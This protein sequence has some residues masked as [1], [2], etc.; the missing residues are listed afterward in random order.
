MRSKVFSWFFALG[1]LLLTSQCAQIVIPGGGPKDIK[2]PMVEKYIP[3]SAA[4]NFTAKSIVI[5]FDEFIQLNDLQKELTISP[6][7]NIQP[8]V[9]VK[10]K[11]LLIDIKDTL[12]KN[13]TYVLN[14]GNSIKDFTEG[15][16]KADF[17]YIFSTGGYIDT[18]KLSGT[19]KNAYDQKTDKGILV[20]LY[21]SSDDSVPYKKGPSYFARTNADGTYRITNIRPGTYKAFALKETNANFKYDSPDES[22]AFSD[23]LIKIRKNTKL[24]L[25]LF[26]EEPKKQRMLK[27][28]VSGYGN[29]T[30]MYA[31]PVEKISFR[32]LNASTPTETFITEYSTGRDTIQ[33]WSP[34]FGKDSLYFKVIADEK[35]VDTMKTCTCLFEKQKAGRADVFKLVMNT[36]VSPT[37]KFDI[38]KNVTLRFNHPINTALSR[39]ENVALTMNS[40]RIDYTNRDSIKIGDR[41]FSFKFP[42]IPDSTYQLNIP[43]ATFTDIFNLKNDTMKIKF[44]VQE[45]KFYGTLKL[46][47][48]MKDKASILQFI[49]DK[50]L[51]YEPESS[52]KGIFMYTYLPPGNY[53]LRIIYDKDRNGKW[54]PGNYTTHR[55]PEKVIYYP[56]PVTI[57][58]NWDSEI[59]WKV[60]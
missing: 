8:E 50:G 33:I 44:Q 31:K 1:C 41:N 23:T 46:N 24:D 21:E 47:L 39:I 14:F 51:I 35:T 30:I 11:I 10:G 15:N 27:N 42:L 34:K 55:Q 7:M 37:A 28:A 45:E 32:A 53:T 29:F 38:N 5:S 6:P 40:Q 3:D 57:R 12:K 22:I 58:S 54:T 20:M 13:T 60:E 48:K 25:Q 26:R 49:N 4:T 9:K 59:E 16:I 56:T 19:V 18:L 2:P 43:P 36:N 52:D 17:Q